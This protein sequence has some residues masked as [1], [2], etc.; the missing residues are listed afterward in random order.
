MNLHV[1]N[2]ITTTLTRI[3]NLYSIFITKDRD[4]MEMI[5]THGYKI[6]IEVNQFSQIYHSKEFFIIRAN[7]LEFNVWLTIGLIKI[8][9]RK[10]N[11]KTVRALKGF[12]MPVET[13]VK[14]GTLPMT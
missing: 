14:R 9:S 11:L 12:T 13:A 2:K 3:T 10:I 5:S 6:R 8:H 7:H 1:M 4:F